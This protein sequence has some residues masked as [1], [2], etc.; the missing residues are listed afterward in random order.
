[1]NISENLMKQC[2]ENLQDLHKNKNY[3]I[4]Y[5]TIFILNNKFFSL[6]NNQKI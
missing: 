4:I 1:M 3:D 5:A 2:I 6:E